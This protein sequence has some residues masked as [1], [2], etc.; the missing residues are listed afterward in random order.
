MEA[1]GFDNATELNIF[2]T[3][4]TTGKSKHTRHNVIGTIN[5]KEI[6]NWH[7]IKTYDTRVSIDLA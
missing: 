3:N 4:S 5:L 2:N 7:C 1:R 6:P